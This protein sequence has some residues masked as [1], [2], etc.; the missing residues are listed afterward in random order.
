VADSTRA[1]RSHNRERR[2][3]SPPAP[4]APF[5]GRERE[6]EVVCALLR[7]PD[8]RLLTL[9]GPGGV[10][11]TR[12]ALRVAADLTPEFPGGTS[13][14]A[15]A[16]IT[17]PAFVPSATAHALGVP[18]TG[19]RE[20]VDALTACLA[21]RA[22][23]LVL[24]NFEQVLGAASDVARLL[25]ACPRLKVLVTSREVLHLYGEQAYL[26]PPL[27]LPDL[28][29]L[30]PLDELARNDA[31]RLFVER[32][33]AADPAFALTDEN[34]AAVSAICTR[35]DGLPLAI[36]LAATRVAL[37]PPAALL[38]RLERR[39]PLLTGG[40]R[41]LPARLQTMR[42]AIAWSYDLL[43]PPEQALFRRL[44]VF[45][46]GFDLDA[47]ESVAGAAERPGLCVLEGIASLASKSL[48]RPLDDG[49]TPRFG[50]LETI[51]EYGLERLAACTEESAVRSAH[52][53]H[54]L[55]LA[56]QAQDAW[57]T[58][59]QRR[60]FD[61][62]DREHDN[63]R[64][65][66]RWAIAQRDGASAQRL[67]GALWI[68]WFVRGF[69]AEGRTWLEQALAIDGGTSLTA[70]F[71]ATFGAGQLARHRGDAR[72]AL[73]LAEGV[74]AEPEI[75]RAPIM[76]A[77]ALFLLGTAAGDVNDHEREQAAYREA[78]GLFLDHGDFDGAARTLGKLAA[79][80]WRSGDIEGFAR[81]SEEKLRLHRLTGSIW[82]AADA[83][84][85]L[86]E[87]ARLRGEPTRALSL[88]REALGCYTEVGNR[89]GILETLRG[90]A[91]IAMVCRQP[92]VA[93]RLFGAEDA[94]RR[95]D[96]VVLAADLQARHVSAVESVRAA[97]DRNAL[98]SAWSAAAALSLEAAVAE[99]LSFAPSLTL[100]ADAPDDATARFG[101]TDRELEVLRLV[102]AGKSNPEIGEALFISP[103]TAQ[104]HV[105][106]ILAKLGVAT[107]AEAAAAAVRDGLV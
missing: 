37:F 9:T 17:D 106:N 46:G 82:G 93:A 51:R 105:T 30:P 102:V 32:A 14:V 75:E 1:V 22:Y 99:A 4:L 7:H 73:D 90:I 96:G 56:L 100:P 77:L 5:V 95:T 10:G 53:A 18:V 11:K 62:I 76:R 25:A 69:F 72:R 8:V 60:W 47:A 59:D 2:G 101:L 71:D 88:R 83:L 65:A 34:A 40:A 50:M 19:D 81:H 104:T 20:P 12:L 15:L 48:I 13:W 3:A 16:P 97:I 33:H 35:L 44:A 87:V 26:V 91:T 67:A 36:E 41:D 68:F 45:V 79:V 57:F 86:A 52:L 66:L 39:L 98:A 84:S 43:G 89:L 49:E 42:D 64:A 70:R 38:V 54:F 61:R 31:V 24:D 63:L 80:A 103:R 107:R 92:I 94:L 27:A 74:L 21:D 78:L 29:R 6:R 85:N 55:A 58:G 23:L 28:V